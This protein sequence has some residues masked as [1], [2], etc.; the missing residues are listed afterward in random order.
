[1]GEQTRISAMNVKGMFNCSASLFEIKYTEIQNF[2]DVEAPGK[3][4]PGNLLMNDANEAEA[5]KSGPEI[6]FSFFQCFDAACSPISV[7]PLPP[8]PQV[9]TPTFPVTESGDANMLFLVAPF[10]CLFEA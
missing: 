3:E 4:E 10:K 2:L 6:G 1:M 9:P 7:I 8:M 5:P